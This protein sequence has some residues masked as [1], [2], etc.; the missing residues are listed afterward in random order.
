MAASTP[1]SPNPHER[2]QPTFTHEPEVSETNIGQP[3]LYHHSY[4]DWPSPHPLADTHFNDAFRETAS[5]PPSFLDNILNPI[6]HSANDN[7]LPFGFYQQF[8]PLPPHLQS[9]HI[10]YIDVEERPAMPPSLNR[11]P[12]L[13]NGYVD[14]TAGSENT[15]AAIPA[16]RRKR[17]SLSPGPSV[18][19]AKNNEG[20]LGSTSATRVP[21]SPGARIEEIDLSDDKIDIQDMLQK[22]RAEVVKAQ[23]KPEEKPTTF[24]TFTCVIC[25]DTPTDITATSCGHLFCHTCLMEALIAGENRSGPNEPKRSQCPVCRKFINRTK[26]ADIIPLLMKKGLATQPRKSSLAAPKVTS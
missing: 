15:S 7:F 5:P 17:N 11:G 18:K 26:T 3:D 2:R 23:Q 24:N 9:P 10:P 21:P 4:I 8:S 19:R 1:Q 22:Q 13:P 12:R 14:L 6:S 20:G 25:M 16:T